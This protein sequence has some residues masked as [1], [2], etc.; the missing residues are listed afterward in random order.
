MR[1]CVKARR[2]TGAPES[3][4][5]RTL[6]NVVDSVLPVCVCR[7]RSEPVVEEVGATGSQRG[8]KTV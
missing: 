4:L 2:S 1:R 8:T 6:D 5:L 3:T 7:I